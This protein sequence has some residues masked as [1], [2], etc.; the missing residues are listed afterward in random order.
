[1]SDNDELTDLEVELEY[2]CRLLV[3]NCRNVVDY[4]IKR[5]EVVLTINR[6]S[7]GISLDGPTMKT[8]Y[9]SLTEYLE[10][11]GFKIDGFNVDMNDIDPGDAADV[12]PRDIGI[13]LDSEKA[14]MDHI[15]RKWLRQQLETHLILKWTETDL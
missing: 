9:S 13:D 15:R 2:K 10:A 7:V 3:E 11:L 6:T 8:E 1:M 4:T 14:N 5:D 12:V